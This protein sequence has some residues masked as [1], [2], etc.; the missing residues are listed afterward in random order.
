MNMP[1]LVDIMEKGLNTHREYQT[2]REPREPKPPQYLPTLIN[3]RL[4]GRIKPV[5]GCFHCHYAREAQQYLALEAGE[6][7]PDK[8]WI[9]P[10]PKRLGLIMDQTTQYRVRQIIPGSP[11]D[12]AG[13]RAGDNLQTLEKRRVLTKYDIQQILDQM[14]GNPGPLSYS[15]LRDQRL[16]SGRLEL[17]EEWRVGDPD[18]YLWRVR[19]V[20]TEHM[21]KFLPTPGFIG[22]NLAEAEKASLGLEKDQF[23]L[24]VTQLNQGAHV[25]GIRS[26]DIIVGA[27]DRTTFVTVRDFYA[28]CERLRRLNR[29]IRMR[30]LRQ[31]SEMN[32]MMGIDNL[33]YSR[34]EKA[35]RVKLGFIVQELPGDH[36]LRVGHVTD[37]SNADRTGIALGDQVIAVE[38]RPVNN[39]AMLE[40]LLNHKSPGDLLTMAITR[41]G[42]PLQFSFVLSGEDER[43]NNL[44]RLSEPITEDG[45][46]LDCVITIRLPESK[47]IYSVYRESFGQPTQVE[48]RGRGYR[49]LG[50]LEESEPVLFDDDGEEHSW[51]LGGDVQ[52]LQ[53]IQVTSRRQFQ[54]LLHVYAQV[55]DDRSCYEF[56]AMV[57]NDGASQTFTEFR[58][59]FDQQP[60]ISASPHLRESGP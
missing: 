20:Y 32:V 54:L 46:V 8:F 5:F 13:I 10:L 58:G 43:E 59:D 18:D 45:Q 34:V 56:R 50:K 30:L 29:D 57:N 22:T 31:G 11:A 41:E 2:S 55:C 17:P 38:G 1:G 24:R 28:W 36:G 23:A 27:G 3:E 51:I 4:K 9:W 15:L 40:N 39:V 47:H 14:N 42:K 52:F 37:D 12:L 35:P 33:N 6:W 7:S 19:N 21:I 49:L 26:G 60:L 16:I 48:F 53:T 25:S 44:A